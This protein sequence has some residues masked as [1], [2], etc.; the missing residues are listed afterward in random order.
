MLAIN[1]YLHLEYQVTHCYYKAKVLQAAAK[2]STHVVYNRQ[3]Y[4]IVGKLGEDLN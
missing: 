1:T 4:H 3:N 2:G